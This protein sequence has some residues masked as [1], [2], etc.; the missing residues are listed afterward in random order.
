MNEQEQ[1]PE[2]EKREDFRTQDQKF[3]DNPK[4]IQLFKKLTSGLS[5]EAICKD[6]GMT[7]KRIAFILSHPSF[8]RRLQDWINTQLFDFQV[9]SLMELPNIYQKLKEEFEKRLSLATDDTIVREFL[10]FYSLRPE[11]KKIHPDLI[12]IVFNVWDKNPKRSGSSM[13]DETRLREIFG[14]KPLELPKETKKNDNG[15]KK[16]PGNTVTGIEGE[17]ENPQVDRGEQ[18]EEQQGQ[19]Y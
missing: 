2:K 3:W 16:Q 18:T 7:D 14:Y 8:D 4:Y 17:A 1:E 19:T 6:M 15:E 5:L 10:K 13:K 12:N 9:K 11:K